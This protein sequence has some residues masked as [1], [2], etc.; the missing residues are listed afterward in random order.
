MISNE[1]LVNLSDFILSELNYAL[2]LLNRWLLLLH[3]LVLVTT[4]V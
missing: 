1:L 4:H 2:W 3:L